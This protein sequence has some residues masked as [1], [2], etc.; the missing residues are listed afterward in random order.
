[1]RIATWFHAAAVAAIAA[2]GCSTDFAQA[3]GSEPRIVLKGHDPVAYFTEGKPVMGSARFSHDWD[4]ARYHFASAGNR[5]RFAGDPDRYAPRYSGYCTGS[6]SKGIRNE[7]DPEIWTIVDGKLF[8]FGSGK[9]REVGLA[10]REKLRAD[11]VGVQAL[12]QKHWET[13]RR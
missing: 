10:A 9:G 11:P 6:M 3:A 4:G 2:F 1:M 7:G 8:F 5:E 12:A 13:L